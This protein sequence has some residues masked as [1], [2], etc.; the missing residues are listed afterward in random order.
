[1]A[2]SHGISIKG[3]KGRNC[4]FEAI[5]QVV[6]RQGLKH[7]RLA[8]HYARGIADFG[9][10]RVYCGRLIV[11]VPQCILL[12]ILTD[13]MEEVDD[14]ALLPYIPGLSLEELGFIL[15][16]HV[17]QCHGEQCFDLVLP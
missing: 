5:H 10:P 2:M 14:P 16:V 4:L 13:L 9:P 6:L 17:P 1:M 8:R 12:D 11:S 15:H 3:G 7:A